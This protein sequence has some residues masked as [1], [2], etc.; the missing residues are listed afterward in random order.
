MDASGRLPTF[1]WTIADE[2]LPSHL[3]VNYW[4]GSAWNWGDQGAIP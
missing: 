2:D 3:D 1:L 4:N